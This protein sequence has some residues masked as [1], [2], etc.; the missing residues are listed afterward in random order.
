MSAVLVIANPMP[1]DSPG[2]QLGSQISVYPDALPPFGYAHQVRLLSV[3]LLEWCN[4]ADGLRQCA[5]LEPGDMVDS[6]CP[7]ALGKTAVVQD[8]V[9][10]LADPSVEGFSYPIVL[11]GVVCGGA[12][13]GALCIDVFVKLIA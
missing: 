8:R 12:M 2:I 1:F 11:R 3:E 13:L 4:F 5:V 7:K 9:D 6:F 10:A